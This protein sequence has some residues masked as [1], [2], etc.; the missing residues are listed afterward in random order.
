MC[1]CF[2]RAQKKLETLLVLTKLELGATLFL[3]LTVSQ[4]TVNGV[5]VKEVNKAQQPIYYINKVFLD[6]ET[7]YRLAK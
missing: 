7:R 1:E 5:L 3:Y 6:A 2:P 4:N